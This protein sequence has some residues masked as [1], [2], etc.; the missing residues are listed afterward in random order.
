MQSKLVYFN[1]SYFLS[2]P[3]LS[4][5]SKFLTCMS[6]HVAEGAWVPVGPV[7]LN[8]EWGERDGGR[9][10]ARARSAETRSVLVVSIRIIS[11]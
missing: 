10:W 7:F 1:L 6:C 2:Q 4:Q 5:P 3:S 8:E 11:I 9:A